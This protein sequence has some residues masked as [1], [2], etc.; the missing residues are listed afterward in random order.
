MF[1]E[2]GK[3]FFLPRV[4]SGDVCVKQI[5][6][7]LFNNQSD[8]FRKSLL[9]LKFKSFIPQRE[10][11]KRIHVLTEETDQQK[12]CDRNSEWEDPHL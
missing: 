1:L 5:L 2:K 11:E 7:D 12:N 8:F 9:A 6:T 3:N 10:N 4:W